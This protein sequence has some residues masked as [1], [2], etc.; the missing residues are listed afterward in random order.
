[1]LPYLYY[2]LLVGQQVTEKG[3][4]R[5]A[6]HRLV[7]NEAAFAAGFGQHDR[8]CHLTHLLQMF[9]PHLHEALALQDYVRFNYEQSLNKVCSKLLISSSR[10]LKLN[11][12][13]VKPSS[14][15]VGWPVRRAVRM[16]LLHAPPSPVICSKA[17]R[18]VLPYC[19]KLS[20][21]IC[22]TFWYNHFKYKDKVVCV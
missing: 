13:K 15:L 6:K 22:N 3:D 5:L 14:G 12:R 1:M 18:S 8:F 19:S 11:R 7:R 10:M 2:R 20:W 4:E 16:G 17:W 21:A 9:N